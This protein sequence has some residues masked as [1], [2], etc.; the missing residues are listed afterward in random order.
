MSVLG[1]VTKGHEII[2]LIAVF[3]VISIGRTTFGMAE[4]ILSFY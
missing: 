2:S 3:I 1:R 4:E